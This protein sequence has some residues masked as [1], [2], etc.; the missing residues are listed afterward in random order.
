MVALCHMD[1]FEFFESRLI[2]SRGRLQYKQRVYLL[3]ESSS[4]SKRKG[5]QEIE[6]LKSCGHVGPA[7]SPNGAIKLKRVFSTLQCHTHQHGCWE[8]T[9][10]GGRDELALAV[11]NWPGLRANVTICC[12]VCFQETLAALR[13][14]AR[15]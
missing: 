9:S 12:L 3:G 15:P 2:W 13:E 1:Y 6:Q 11:R 7:A 14:G 5:V 4:G 8:E 10:R